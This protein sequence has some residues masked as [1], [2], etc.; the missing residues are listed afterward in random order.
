MKKT[1]KLAIGIIA[2]VLLGVGAGWYA[3]S[4]SVEPGAFT[5]LDAESFTQL[6]NEFNAAVGDVCVILLLSPT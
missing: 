2:L 6:R 3:I 5:D 1:R 4:D